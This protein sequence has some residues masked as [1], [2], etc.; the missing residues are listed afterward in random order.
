MFGAT[1]EPFVQDFLVGPL[2]ITNATT[3]V[4]DTG[5]NTAANASIRVYDA[6][7]S[8]D[9]YSDVAWGMADIVSDLLNVTMDTEDDLND[10]FSIWGIDP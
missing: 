9:Y 1:E 6:D 5:S 8:Y 10:I 2:P 3:F 4:P 7:A